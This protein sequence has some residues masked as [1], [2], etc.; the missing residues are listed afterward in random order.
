[1]WPAFLRNLLPLRSASASRRRRR[2]RP[3]CRP[4]IEVLEDRRQPS[5]VAGI[6]PLGVLSPAHGPARRVSAH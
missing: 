6:G 2:D 1:M 3:L 5:L 4:S